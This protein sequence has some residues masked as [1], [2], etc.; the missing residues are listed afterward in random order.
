MGYLGK[1]STNIP[2]NLASK[3]IKTLQN[4]QNKE[5][6]QQAWLTTLS[7]SRPKDVEFANEKDVLVS[8]R[9][10]IEFRRAC[11]VS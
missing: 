2:Q 3:P 1:V 9:I 4:Y 7:Y 5:T 6:S 10:D 8:R 11:D